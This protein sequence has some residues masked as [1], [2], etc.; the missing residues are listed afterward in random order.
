MYCQSL[1]INLFYDFKLNLIPIFI[2]NVDLATENILRRHNKKHHQA[3]NKHIYQDLVNMRQFQSFSTVAK[4]SLSDLPDSEGNSKNHSKSNKKENVTASTIKSHPPPRY[5]EIEAF[6]EVDI[7]NPR[8]YEPSETHTN[9]YTDYELVTRTNL[10][11]FPRRISHVRRRYSDF[12]LLRRCLQ[13]EVALADRL[14][15]VRVPSLPGKLLWQNRFD[16]QV[17]EQRRRDLEQWLRFVAGHP[18]IQTN[19]AALIRFLQQENFS[20]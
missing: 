17:I 1:V 20:G 3:Q 16:P 2:L 7:I 12:E 19:S 11:Q 14:A 6:I 8:I 15:K 10:P 18:L 4:E 13:R 9:K 5:N